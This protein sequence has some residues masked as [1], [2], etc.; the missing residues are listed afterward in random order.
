MGL[1]HVFIAMICVIPFIETHDFKQYDGYTDP[2]RAE[3][4]YG[5]I[6]HVS[7]ILDL[8]FGNEVFDYILCTEVLEHVPEPIGA[9]REM[10]RVLEWWSHD[11]DGPLGVGPLIR[12]RSIFTEAIHHTGTEM[13]AERFGL[14]VQL[15]Q[16]NR[17]SATWPKNVPVWL[18]HWRNIGM[19]LVKMR[20]RSV[21]CLAN[22]C[23]DICMARTT[24]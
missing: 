20:M 1:G 22:C 3:G 15:V 6:D 2:A 23:R 18:G 7:D 9:I 19:L 12:S 5:Q 4:L 10:A 8:P 21:P 14:Q 13:V 17:G 16:A 11:F 24:S